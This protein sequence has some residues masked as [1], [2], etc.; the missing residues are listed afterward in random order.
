LVE[1]LIV[2]E[3]LLLRHHAD[4]QEE[5]KRE[6]G[7]QWTGGEESYRLSG[8]DGV[9]TLTVICDV[10]SELEAYFKVNYPKALERIKAL[11]EEKNDSSL[12]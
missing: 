2:G 6:R 12:L 5:G 3:F 7:N 9:T 10:P 8:G 4:T 11:A 1:K